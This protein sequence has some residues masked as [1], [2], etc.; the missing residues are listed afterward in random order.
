MIFI[1]LNLN[2]EI[3]FFKKNLV[4]LILLQI[5]NLKVRK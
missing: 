5:Q 2:L 4:Y 1:F 3:T